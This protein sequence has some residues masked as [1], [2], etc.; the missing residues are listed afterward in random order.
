MVLP[1]AV[2]NVESNLNVFWDPHIFEVEK[3][4]VLSVVLSSP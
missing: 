4:K 1:G 2:N 3:F